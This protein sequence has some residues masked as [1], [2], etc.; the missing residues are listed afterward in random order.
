MKKI[1]LLVTSL[2]L[3]NFTSY[4]DIKPELVTNVKKA[5]TTI[6]T[7]SSI[8]AYGGNGSWQG[9]GFIADKNKGLIVTNSHVVGT[10][11]I[12]DY[13]LTFHNGQKTEAK[14]AYYDIWQDVA[15]LKFDPKT[16]PADTTSISFSDK[17]TKIDQ[18]VFIMGNNE[19]QE[20]S[21]HMGNISNLND[22]NGHLPQQSYIINLNSAGGSSGSPVMDTEGKAVALN[23]GGSKTYAIALK[24]DYVKNILENLGKNQ[25]PPRQHI[26]AIT[27]IYSLD[28]AV[29]HRNFPEETMTKYL[30]DFPDAKNKVIAVKE[31]IP[32][33][34][35]EKH[36][37]AGDII[38]K[39]NGKHIT[40][41]L[42]IFDHTMDNTTDH[43]V[44]LN[45]YRDGKDFDVE[46]PLYNIHDYQI[47]KL[48][49]FAGAVFFQAD[50]Y[51]SSTTGTPHGALAVTNIISGS[52]FSVIP[53]SFNFGDGDFFRLS[54]IKLGL[55]FVD[56]LDDIVKVIPQIYKDKYSTI[57]YK[58]YLPYRKNYT[59]T[60]GA[61]NFNQTKLIKDIKF[62]AI[63]NNPRILEF[64]LED[65]IWKS[66]PIDLGE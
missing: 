40:S 55:N 56:N 22:I 20:F 7:R 39:I 25:L 2:I 43:K 5:I 24:G 29:K 52:S 45:I 49:N 18:Q 46:V 13:Y 3:L 50:D 27:A 15:I 11:A 34:P 26:G 35:C 38:W 42:Y 30:K 47:N 61:F 8:S 44:K 37:K 58:N 4:A 21:F 33:S 64:D 12:A 53:E 66:E 32:G 41:K 10:G 57:E 62:D 9:T 63:D 19:A 36:L 60:L 16:I 59:G 65:N 51:Y 28:D 14:L 17:E 31:C 23:Y 48:V 1:I 6:H 54:P